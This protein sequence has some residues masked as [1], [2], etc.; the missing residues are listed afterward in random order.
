MALLAQCRVIRILEIAVSQ[1][2]HL[3]RL[4]WDQFETL[5]SL[6][7]DLI[8]LRDAWLLSRAASLQ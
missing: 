3:R 6:V 5:A 2:A 4:L 1:S 8:E 7:A